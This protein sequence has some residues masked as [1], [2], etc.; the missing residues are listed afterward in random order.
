M[1]Y[2]FNPRLWIT[3]LSINLSCFLTPFFLRSHVTG[4]NTLYC[5]AHL[6]FFPAQDLV[7]ATC[8]NTSVSFLTAELPHHIADLL[9]NLPST[10]DWLFEV[11]LEKIKGHWAMVAADQEV[12]PDKIPNK[13]MSHPLQ[14][15]VGEYLHPYYGSFNVWLED[16]QEG[17]EGKKEAGE[18]KNKAL[19]STLWDCRTL[20]SHLHFD[21]FVLKH[22]HPG[23]H[24]MYVASFHTGSNGKII[25]INLEDTIEFKRRKEV[26]EEEKEE[27]N[28]AEGVPQAHVD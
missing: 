9:L 28:A 14:A 6:A 11:A 25:S 3:L 24:A 10:Q 16:L 2:Y 5:A 7:V 27:K 22:D 13:P 15:Y 19:V 12:T 4:G 23:F 1:H 26:K 17:E 8:V 21:T 18:H 20:I